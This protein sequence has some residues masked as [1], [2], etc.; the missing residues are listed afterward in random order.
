LAPIVGFEAAF[1]IIRQTGVMAFR[2]VLAYK[3]INIAKAFHFLPF[4]WLPA[5]FDFAVINRR[6]TLRSPL[7]CEEKHF[8]G[9]FWRKR[10]LKGF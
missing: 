2:I 7:R 10:G 8:R 6:G 4:F 9:V 5:S 1:Q 3:D